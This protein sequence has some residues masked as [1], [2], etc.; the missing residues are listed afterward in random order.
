[1]LPT[2]PLQG[3]AV[4]VVDDVLDEGVTLAEIIGYCR[5]EGAASVESAVLVD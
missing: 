1:L 5:K 2:L 3:R 4:L